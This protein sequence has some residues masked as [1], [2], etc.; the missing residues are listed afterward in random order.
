MKTP[1]LQQPL[2][3]LHAF[4]S[5][6]SYRLQREIVS[7][8]RKMGHIPTGIYFGASPDF[9]DRARSGLHELGVS[10]VSLDEIEGR[11]NI[12]K[13]G[14]AALPPLTQVGVRSYLSVLRDLDA[15]TGWV[16]RSNYLRRVRAAESVLR[17]F[18]F[19]AVVCS[20]DGISSDLALMR[21]ARSVGVPVVDVPFGNGTRHEIEVDL[22]Q[23]NL[24]G[25]LIAC[26]GPRLEVLRRLAPQWLKKGRF[27]D[28]VMLPPLMILAM[29]SIGITLRDSW[30]IH[31]GLSDLLCVENSVAMAQ[32][33][34]EGI[35]PA[36]LCDT[37][38][39]Y[40]DALY[41][42]LAEAPSAGA[43]FRKPKKINDGE[44]KILVS[45]PPDYHETY[46]GAS[47][48][49]TYLEM[50]QTIFGYLRTI[51]KTSLTVSLH[52]ACNPETLKLVADMGIDVSNDYI[53]DLIPKH[54]IFTTYFSSTIRWAL[55]SG[56]PVVNLDAYRIG[57]STYNRAPGFMNAT[58]FADYKQAMG[59]L[60]SDGDFF[61]QMA[62]AQSLDAPNWG[63]VDGMATNR[64]LDAT[65]SFVAMSF[66]QKRVHARKLKE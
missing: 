17:E 24:D 37:G 52:P 31:G 41:D 53:I 21:A 32:Y 22:A 64:I 47:T 29:E 10:T 12:P 16:W 61:A 39:P 57:L 33:R 42:A 36:K 58:D 3:F 19:D 8:A 13:F 34:N 55:A 5:E 50:T 48:F 51:P 20:E 23:K 60:C 54:D 59:R 44:T 27:E 38:T 49:D 18:R 7:R 2:R 35:P 1:K 15:Q 30:I 40:C 14:W 9:F 25:R 6:T 45:W 56:K 28:S 63:I 46:P 62:G 66:V 26:T 11:A 4:G 43:A 65:A